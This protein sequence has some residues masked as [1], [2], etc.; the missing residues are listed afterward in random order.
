MLFRSA[1]QQ[2][3]QAQNHIHQLDQ[4]WAQRYQILESEL[5][6]QRAQRE[7]REE[8][9]QRLTEKLRRI[10][11]DWSAKYQV[12]QET[13]QKVNQ[14]WEEQQQLWQVQQQETQLCLD[15]AQ[16]ELRKTQEE[17]GEKAKPSPGEA[18][19]RNRCRPAAEPQREERGETSDP[20]DPANEKMKERFR[21]ELEHL[22]DM[23]K[24]S[25]LS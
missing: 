6:Q 13:L 5:Q 2:Q 11:Q 10:E 23:M 9:I 18:E 3:N 7:Q 12:L 8:D 19:A 16:Q 1:K 20:D 21:K 14:Q 25:G 17:L 22:R 15:T 24:E 4:D